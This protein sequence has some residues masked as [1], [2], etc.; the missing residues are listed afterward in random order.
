VG[1]AVV[2][3]AAASRVMDRVLYDPE[4]ALGFLVL[5]RRRAAPPAT[6]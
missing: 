3:L 6:S 4:E 5:A 1:P 2:G